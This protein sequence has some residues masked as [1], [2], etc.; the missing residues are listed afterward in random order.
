MQYGSGAC[1]MPILWALGPKLGWR[2]HL[3]CVVRSASD[4]VNALMQDLGNSIAEA[5]ICDNCKAL[6][7]GRWLTCLDNLSSS[8]YREILVRQS[9]VS[10]RGRGWQAGQWTH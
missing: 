4:E 5:K 1:S 8:A 6:L 9:G 7:L 2:G 10:S 3:L